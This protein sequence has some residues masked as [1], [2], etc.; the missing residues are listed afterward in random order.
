[1]EIKLER[2]ITVNR[3]KSIDK[4]MILCYNLLLLAGASY[5]VYYKDASAWLFALA[6]VFGAKWSEKDDE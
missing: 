3:V 2:P 1:M 4:L 5:L 6:L